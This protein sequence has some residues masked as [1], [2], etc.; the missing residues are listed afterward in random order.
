MTA[1]FSKFTDGF[2]TDM[3]TICYICEKECHSKALLIK[4]IDIVHSLQ[5]D[6][7]WECFLC[8][9]TFSK[10]VKKCYYIHETIPYVDCFC[11]KE[12]SESISAVCT[13][14]YDANGGASY[15]CNICNKM[16][17]DKSELKKHMRS[18]HV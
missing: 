1:R 16:Y 6:S 12:H 8:Q 3:G 4:H 17:R 18:I 9:K 13:E 14:C 2:S 15:F 7:T 11:K 5:D 10:S